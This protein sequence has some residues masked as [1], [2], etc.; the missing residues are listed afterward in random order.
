MRHW[1]ERPMD[2]GAEPPSLSTREARR[3][4][5]LKRD[6][7]V[8]I[9]RRCRPARTARTA[10]LRLAVTIAT[11]SIIA[12]TAAVTATTAAAAIEHHQCPAI[13]LQYNLG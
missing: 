13:A 5:L 4:P 11:G 8:D 10:A 6:I 7:V 9:A 2:D 1:S 3:K 12:V